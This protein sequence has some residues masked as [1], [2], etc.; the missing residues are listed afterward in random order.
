MA[1]DHGGRKESDTTEQLTQ[2]FLKY[3]SSCSSSYSGTVYFP[4]AG[5]GLH[6]CSE[7]GLLF[8][9]VCGLLTAVASSRCG[10]GS[11]LAGSTGVVHV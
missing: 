2:Q 7:Q 10:T 9:A 6:C 4:L 3:L 11:R 5:R 1:T 8:T